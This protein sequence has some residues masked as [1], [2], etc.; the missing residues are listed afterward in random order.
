MLEVSPTIA[1]GLLDYRMMIDETSLGNQGE[2]GN[3]TRDEIRDEIRDG[4]MS[5][6]RTTSAYLRLSQSR[7]PYASIGEILRQ[8][9]RLEAD[10]IG[11]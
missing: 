7:H 9:E 2:P 1:R 11:R 3:G 5:M 8:V 10:G 4:I 6:L